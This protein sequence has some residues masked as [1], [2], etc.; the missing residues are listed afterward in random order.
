PG[1]CS[2][3][4]RSQTLIARVLPLVCERGKNRMA[5]AFYRVER[6]L[7]VLEG[8]VQCKLGIVVTLL[9]ATELV[10]DVWRG[11]RGDLEQLRHCFS[12]EVG[13]VS[14]TEGFSQSLHDEREHRVVGEL[15]TAAESCRPQPQRVLSERVE[16]RR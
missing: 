2:E 10:R 13:A 5:A 11:E 7:D 9:D 4:L 6:E 15:E 14:N 12:R 1:D 3:V 16:H 8:K